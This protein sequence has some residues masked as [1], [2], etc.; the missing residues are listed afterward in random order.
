MDPW[1][2]DVA[3]WNQ[4]LG[5]LSVQNSIPHLRDQFLINIVDKGLHDVIIPQQVTGLVGMRSLAHKIS[6]G[7]M[8]RPDVLY[9]DSAHERDESILEISVAYD[10]LGDEGILM[11]DDYSIYWMGLTEDIWKFVDTL[12]CVKD[13]TVDP[14]CT[15]WPPGLA[16]LTTDAPFPPDAP[17]PPRKPTTAQARVLFAGA[18]S[19]W[20]IRKIVPFPK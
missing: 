12:P 20:M 19:Q 8:P 6:Q 16:A 5:V 13:P 17:Q 14:R 4:L 2:G 11:G 10:L 1:T 18:I 15:V 3:M 9:L 7:K